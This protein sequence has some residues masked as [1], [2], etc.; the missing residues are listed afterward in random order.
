M[1]AVRAEDVSTKDILHEGI[2][3]IQ[4]QTYPLGENAAALCSRALPNAT[5]AST[6]DLAT[7]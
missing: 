5:L 1:R 4:F 2:R 3:D 7:C 6:T